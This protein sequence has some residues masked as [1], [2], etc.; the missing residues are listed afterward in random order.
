[1]L[2]AESADAQ[3]RLTLLQA[4]SKSLL[5]LV[6]L[7]QANDVNHPQTT[8]FRSLVESLARTIPEAANPGLPVQPAQPSSFRSD[9]K[10]PNSGILALASEVSML[11]RKL[12]TV[13]EGVQLTDKLARFSDNLRAPLTGFVNQ[14]VQTGDLAADNLQ[15]RDSGRLRQQTASLDQLTDQITR[16]APAMA[17]L[18][19]QRVLPRL[20]QWRKTVVN[21]YTGA[22]KNLILHLVVLALVIAF[23]TGVAVALRRITVNYAHDANRRRMFLV[24]QRTLIW[25]AIVLVIAFAFAP[26]LRSLATFLGLLTAGVAVALQNVILAVV[27]YFLLVGKLGIRVG[28]RLR[29]SGVTGDVIDVGLLQFQLREVDQDNEQL[30]GNVATFSNSFVFVSPATGLLKFGSVYGN[31]NQREVA[32][33]MSRV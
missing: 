24:V 23:L 26:E 19:K 20:T 10:P 21:E 29:I 4:R 14:A 13:D 32:K 12:R 5:N 28:D 30:T 27:G 22:W 1:K 7:I 25:L 16:L 17:A 15:S 9:P 8:D 2:E 3:T 18:D 33:R 11:E 6:D 31:A